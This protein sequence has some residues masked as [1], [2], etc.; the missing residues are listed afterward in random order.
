M[1]TTRQIR[2][3]KKFDTHSHIGVDA[4]NPNASDL[5]QYGKAAKEKNI[6]RA[7]LIGVPL[8]RYQTE[9]G[10]YTPVNWE[11]NG[12]KLNTFSKLNNI[13]G[14]VQQNPFAES[15][16]RLEQQVNETSSPNLKLHF[17]PHVHPLLDTQEHLEYTL[18]QNPI[19]AKIHGS[20]WGIN[21]KDIPKEFF[22]TVRK[23]GV[24][25]LLHTDYSADPQNGNHV[26][27]GANDPL[28]WIDLCEKYDIRASLAHGLRLCEESW[29]RVRKAGNQ[30][31]V[32][33][34]PK[35]NTTGYRVKKR[36]GDYVTDLM[37]MADP[38]KLTYDIDFAWNKDDNDKIDWTLDEDLIGKMND[39]DFEGFYKGNAEKFYRLESKE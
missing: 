35:L 36:G 20:S 15:N 18:G 30:F 8:P 24:P 17:V 23:S 21:P 38:S 10:I 32:G 26:A 6:Q 39:S 4:R 9:S 3:M 33:F 13:S 1:I 12:M 31:I 22:E 28:V 25:L 19:A 7:I 2:K 16:R 11:T 37:E 29:E 5:T 27:I 14:P 34:G